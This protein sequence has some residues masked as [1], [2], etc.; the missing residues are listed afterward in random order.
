M[1]KR[2]IQMNKKELKMTNGK[3]DRPSNNGSQQFR[4]NFEDIDWGN[5]ENNE[6][7]KE[8]VVAFL[9]KQIIKGKLKK[10]QSDS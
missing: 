6:P 8:D 10:L 1:S 5:E 3:G 2:T 9:Q 4:S 7:Y